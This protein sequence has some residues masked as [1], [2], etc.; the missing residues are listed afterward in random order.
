MSALNRTS[1]SAYFLINYPTVTVITFSTESELSPTDT[2][3]LS[4][5]VK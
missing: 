1:N 2:S 4:K 3:V 5:Q